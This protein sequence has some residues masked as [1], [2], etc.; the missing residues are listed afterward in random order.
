MNSLYSKIL[1]TGI[2]IALVLIA[3][4][5]SAN[6][7]SSPVVSPASVTVTG[8]DI[9]Q[10]APNVIGVKD[11]GSHTG[12]PG[13]LLIFE[14]DEQKKSFTYTGNL[15]TEEYLTHPEMYGIPTR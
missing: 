2:F 12:L 7:V 10:V 13:Q 14:Y 3:F 1:L 9:V 5:P 15:D 4:K 6:F 11:N 8:G